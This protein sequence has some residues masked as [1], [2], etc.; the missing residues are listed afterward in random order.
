MRAGWRSGDSCWGFLTLTLRAA[1]CASLSFN[2]SSPLFLFCP[3]VSDSSS[4]SSA[5]LEEWSARNR[6]SSPAASAPLVSGVDKA[7]LEPEAKYSQVTNGHLYS[8]EAAG[9]SLRAELLRALKDQF[10]A[11]WS[12][13]DAGLFPWNLWQP[14]RSPG[15]FIPLFHAEVFRAD[16]GRTKGRERQFVLGFLLRGSIAL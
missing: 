2:L 16:A 6:T 11:R 3:P 15:W 12:V 13:S 7:H 8:S 10:G 14:A 5:K 9:G 1:A 4:F